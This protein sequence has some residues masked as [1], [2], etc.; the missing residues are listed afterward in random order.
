MLRARGGRAG[1]ELLV[2]RETS[3]FVTGQL[4]QQR[5]SQAEVLVGDIGSKVGMSYNHTAQPE[6]RAPTGGS[7][8]SPV[9]RAAISRPGYSLTADSR[10]AKL[11]DRTNNQ[12]VSADCVRQ[13]E[14][15]DE[16]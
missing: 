3:G 13:S 8:S 5:D 11:S 6:Y 15:Q 12:S 1:G 2:S 14:A 10:A 9:L 16:Q 4:L 7:R